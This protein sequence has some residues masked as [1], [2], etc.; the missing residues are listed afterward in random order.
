MKNKILLIGGKGNLGSAILNSKI[1]KNLDSPKKNKLNLLN[2]STIKNFLK[3]KYNLII[4]CAAAARMKECEKNP[5]KAIKINVIGTLNLVREIINYAINFRKKIRLIHIS[6]DGVYPS[7]NGNYSEN[8]PLKPYNVYGWTKLCSESIVK[9]LKNY[10]V[11]RTKFFDKTNIRFNTAATD[12]Y[13]SMIEIQNLVKEIK[14]ISSKNFI[15]IIN[16]GAKKKSD[17]ENY[18]KYKP[19]I[20]PCKRKDILKNLNFKIA[21]DSSMNLSLLKKIKRRN[22]QST[23]RN[24]YPYL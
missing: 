21:K 22:G 1:F 3:K 6:T 10:V 2:K 15:G 19:N 11:I 12:I 8:G 24:N 13:T 9:K 14:N 16:I 4:N 23:I 7:I 17:F 20:K 18:K 5:N